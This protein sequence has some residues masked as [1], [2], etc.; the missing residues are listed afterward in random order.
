MVELHIGTKDAKAFTLPSSTLKKHAIALGSSG[1]G[2]TVFTKTIIEEC[3]LH[4]IPSLIFDVQGD[5]CSL[6]LF[7]DKKDRESHN[8]NEEIFSTLKENSDV[9]IY[10]P[11][12]SKGVSICINP[13]SLPEAQL[14]EEEAITI[15]HDTAT[16]LTKLLGHTLRTSKGKYA[17]AVVYSV[18]YYSYANN[19]EL[20]DFESLIALLRNPPD[21]LQ[22]DISE[23]LEEKSNLEF[24]IKQ[25]KYLTIGQKKLLF[26]FGMPSD[27][28][29]FYGKNNDKTPLSIIYLNT[30]GS[31]EQKEYFVARICNQLYQWMLDNPSEALQGLFVMDEIATFLPAGSEKPV[32]KPI[33]K[34]LFKQARKYGIGC[35][36]AT[37][38]PGDIDYKAFSQ[39]GTWAIGRLNLQ[40]D[41][42]KIEQAL[43]SLSK[44]IDLQEK[45][46]ALQTGE[47]YLY[48][49]DTFKS[50][51]H[52]HTRWLYTQ[53]KT[54]TEQDIADV[55][56][57]KQL[58]T[59]KPVTGAVKPVSTSS[60]E[61]DTKKAKPVLTSEKKTTP[62][63][64][65]EVLG[66]DGDKARN[67]A[68]SKRSKRFL[69]PYTSELLDLTKE[70]RP[71]YAA[72]V[73]VRKGF[74]YKKTKTYT[75]IVD[76]MSGELIRQTAI[77]RQTYPLTKYFIQLNETQLQLAKELHVMKEAYRTVE[78]LHTITGL[79]KQTISK[80]LKLLEKKSIVNHEKIGKFQRWFA[81]TSFTEKSI[82]KLRSTIL[83]T[84]LY[85]N[86]TQTKYDP[87]DIKRLLHQ[88]FD[89]NVSRT[90]LIALP[91][92]VATYS[93][94]RTTNTIRIDG[95]TGKEI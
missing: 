32:C 36:I 38:N 70:L 1:S 74:L 57:G 11:V 34:L 84:D 17:Q 63:G 45:L 68:L 76:A 59:K 93:K 60:N 23:F 16:A 75:L 80:N 33:L 40:Q 48:A 2:K 7:G 4:A 3:A 91:E 22:S 79:T 50:L 77:K 46:P 20:N 18:L 24:L 44:D 72:T 54:L 26:Q 62:T 47:F 86:T 61:P 73:R 27:I 71:V 15:I 35:V 92:Y 14:P 5:L 53:H 83:H 13:L 95:V 41:I 25:L 88:W 37:Q 56:R 31:Q 87:E 67:I 6:A 94:G 29:V 21:E 81:A 43:R 66:M 58:V 49:P 69:G 65:R 52:I 90:E 64:M 9:T 39:F 51:Q 78:E 82:K 89:G 42:K 19:L 30:L 85:H 10:T 12:S 55:M 28:N 8:L